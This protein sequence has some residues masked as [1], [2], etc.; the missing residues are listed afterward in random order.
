MSRQRALPVYLVVLL[1]GLLPLAAACR[2][3][4][5]PVR[6]LLVGDSVT[7]GSAGDWTWRYR[8]AQHLVD[9]DVPFDFVGPD[10]GLLDN[11]TG[12]QGRTPTPTR[13][14]TRTTPP[15]GA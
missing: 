7:Q 10:D 9:A 12:K 15:A 2:S 3:A 4:D 14:S 5:D 6:I 8:L 11:L 1:L 13:T